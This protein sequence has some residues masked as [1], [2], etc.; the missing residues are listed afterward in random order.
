MIKKDKKVI[1]LGTICNPQI[2]KSFGVEKDI[3]GISEIIYNNK[4]S[5]YSNYINKFDNLDVIFLE[6]FTKPNSIAFKQCLQKSSFN[7]EK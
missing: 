7:T 3:K 2:H 6:L 5:D 1:L 4:P